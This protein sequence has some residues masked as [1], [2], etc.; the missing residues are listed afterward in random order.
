MLAK[1]E[2]TNLLHRMHAK[3]GTAGQS[4]VDRSSLLVLYSM[5]TTWT[6]SSPTRCLVHWGTQFCCSLVSPS[7]QL[8]ET[9]CQRTDDHDH[10]LLPRNC[11]LPLQGRV[12]GICIKNAHKPLLSRR[13][14][15][16]PSPTCQACPWKDKSWPF[17]PPTPPRDVLRCPL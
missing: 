12:Y 16:L 6:V 15:N 4:H 11:Q 8:Q 9:R 3:D 1:F 2:L 13:A 14:V 17:L 5:A 7:E 10:V